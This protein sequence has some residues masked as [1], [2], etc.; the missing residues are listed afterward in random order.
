MS[1]ESINFNNTHIGMNTPVLQSPID[2][3]LNYDGSQY[4]TVDKGCNNY[5][6][7][8]KKFSDI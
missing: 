6:N 1:N 8:K 3:H 5:I 7:I 2:K 4:R